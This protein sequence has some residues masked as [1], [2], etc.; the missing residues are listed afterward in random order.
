[1]KAFINMEFRPFV[2]ATVI[3]DAHKVSQILIK[4]TLITLIGV[5]LFRHQR[6][7]KLLMS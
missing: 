4:D 5:E 2:M 7:L 6:P 1:M 3:S